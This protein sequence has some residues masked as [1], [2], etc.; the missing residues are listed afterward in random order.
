MPRKSK[1]SEESGSTTTTTTANKKQKTSDKLTGT[2]R[3]NALQS[4]NKDWKEGQFLLLLL[5]LHFLKCF[6][7]E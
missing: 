2:D 3:K 5:L 4:L 7:N 6:R 1:A